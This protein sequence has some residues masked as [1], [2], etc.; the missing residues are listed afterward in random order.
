MTTSRYILY[1]ETEDEG[2]N[3]PT[4]YEAATYHDLIEDMLGNEEFMSAIP[5]ETR[6][7]M[8]V[9]RDTLCWTLGHDSNASLAT[10]LRSWSDLY[11][12]FMDMDESFDS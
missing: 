1:K 5:Y 4:V 2:L 11:N 8:L 6:Q 10:N 3:R 7:A 12:E 9:V